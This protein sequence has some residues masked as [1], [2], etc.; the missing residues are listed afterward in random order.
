MLDHRAARRE[1]AAQH[2]HAAGRLH[3][4]RRG[5]D[6]GLVRDVL[7]RIGDLADGAPV[8][9]QR[10]AVEM[11]AQLLH[12]L[13]HATGP[14]EMLH[15]VVA[16]RLEIDQ[17][18]HLTADGVELLEI[19]REAGAPRDRGEMHQRIGR[20]ADRLQHRER[21]PEGRR[22][23]DLA[24]ARAL[25]LGHLG[26]EPAAGLGDAQAVGMGRRDRAAA[27][28]APYRAPRRCSP[29]CWRCPSPCRCPGSAP[30]ARSPSR[31]RPPT[32][33]AG[34]VLAPE[35]AAVGA[36]AQDLA[37]EVADQHGP[38]RS[39]GS[40]GRSAL[41]A[42]MSWAGT[43][44]SQPPISTTESH[45]L[46]ADHLLGVH[47]HEVAQEHAGGMGEALVDRDGREDHGQ[48]AGQHDAALHRLDQVGH[49][50]VAR[51]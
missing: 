34:A 20:A 42:A 16:R 29:S 12:Q 44:L 36:G 35:A 7:C 40:P 13:G 43:V 24:G 41:A 28:Q 21:V 14:V 15:V 10:R 8:D 39:A 47:R 3:W 50:A 49:V 25:L 51:D 37:L 11:V 2:R 32:I 30:D 6:D 22:R 18:R 33:G 9:G 31:C 48:R 1:V 26:G 5:A 45:R 23:H 17:H 27:G 46:G 4:A 38:G 19:D